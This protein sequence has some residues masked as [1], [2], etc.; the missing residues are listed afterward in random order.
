MLGALFEPC[1]ACVLSRKDGLIF[2]DAVDTAQGGFATSAR[3]ME[4]LSAGDA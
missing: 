2:V 3:L 4:Y 1:R